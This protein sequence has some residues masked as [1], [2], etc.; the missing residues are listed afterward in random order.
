MVIAFA[1]LASRAEFSHLGFIEDCRKSFLTYRRDMMDAMSQVGHI[2]V[3]A[4][5]VEGEPGLKRSLTIG[6]VEKYLSNLSE[7]YNS[8]L[9]DTSAHGDTLRDCLQDEQPAP[10]LAEKYQKLD[11]E[12][13]NLRGCTFTALETLNSMIHGDEEIQPNDA[14]Q[15]LVTNRTLFQTAYANSD[16]EQ[17][18]RS[19]RPEEDLTKRGADIAAIILTK[20]CL[21]RTMGEISRR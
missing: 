4:Q 2:A 19:A 21:P 15:L 5:A 13:L 16:W 17:S 18:D 9:A 20:G 11:T 7:R 12:D 14:W 3:M 6:D 8:L 1:K 10:S